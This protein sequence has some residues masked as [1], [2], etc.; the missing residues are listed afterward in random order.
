MA[1]HPESLDIPIP[2]LESQFIG[3]KW[4]DR[5]AI[6]VDVMSPTTEESL[7]QVADPTV[8]DADAAVVA[9][10][11]AFDN[12]PW[13]SMSVSDRVTVC[14]RL[15]DL[16]EAR[17]DQLNR[18]WA[19]ESGATLAHGAMINGTAGVSIWRQAL[20]LAPNL[21]WEEERD[22]ALIWREPIGTVLGVL[23]FNGPIVLMGMK[24]I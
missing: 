24:E 11:E 6:L 12:G 15:C 21:P 1:S 7:V 4:L 9:A 5:N 2:G 19:F 22:G 18:A 23:T 3:G 10:R 14:R 13:P 20:E 17:M 16:L 8:Q